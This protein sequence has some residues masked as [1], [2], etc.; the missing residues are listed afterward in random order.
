VLG[1][2]GNQQVGY[3]YDPSWNHAILWTGSAASAVDLHPTNIPL[4]MSEAQATDG[5]HQ[6]GYGLS[7]D[8]NFHALLW[9]GSA[10]T[11]IDLN[12]TQFGG[13][14]NSKAFGI[15]GGQQVGEAYSLGSHTHAAV[16]SGTADS[17][18]DLHPTQF[19]EFNESIAY[20]TNGL[21]QVGVA[22]F[23]TAGDLDRPGVVT[24]SHAMLWDGTA[25]SAV[26]LQLSLPSSFVSS[27]AYSIDAAGDVFGIATDTSGVMH[28][29]EWTPQVPEPSGLA[30]FA[31]GA[32]GVLLRRN[33]VRTERRHKD[34][35]R[36]CAVE[37]LESRRLLSVTATYNGLSAYPGIDQPTIGNS[38]A[39]PDPAIA[40]SPPRPA[41][42]FD[43]PTVGSVVETVNEGIT[44]FDRN[45]IPGSFAMGD[46][47][48][49][50]MPQNTFWASV[51]LTNV[52]DTDL[53]YDTSAN[54]FVAVC[55]SYVDER[56]DGPSKLLIAVSK[57]SSLKPLD[58][59]DSTL[60]DP[61]S[62][63]NIVAIN[64]TS[65]APSLVDQP[66]F[67]ALNGNIYIYGEGNA[68]EFYAVSESKVLNATFGAT[69][70]RGTD[71]KYFEISGTYD[72]GRYDPVAVSGSV[73]LPAGV[74]DYFFAEESGNLFTITVDSHGVPNGSSNVIVMPTSGTNQTYQP[75]TTPTVIDFSTNNA[76]RAWWNNSKLY[77]ADTVE[78][79]D[80]SGGGRYAV[81]WA[82]YSAPLPAST[83]WTVQQQGLE[84]GPAGA[85]AAG[86]P[87]MAVNAEGDMLLAFNACFVY[88][89]DTSY[90][91]VGAYYAIHRAGDAPNTLE[92][93][94]T[95]RDD[96]AGY[97]K[98]EYNRWGDFTSV[99]LDPATSSAFSNKDAS[100]FVMCAEYA[101][102]SDPSQGPP[103][104]AYNWGTEIG[105]FDP[106]LRIK[107]D[108]ANPGDD[109]IVV[110]LA[111]GGASYNITD[112]GVPV[113]L[114][115][116]ATPDQVADLFVDAGTGNNSLTLDVSN[117][118][119]I[120]WAD[121][122]GGDPSLHLIGSN[123]NDTLSFANHDTFIAQL[124]LGDGTSETVRDEYW[125]PPVTYDTAAGNDT[126]SVGTSPTVVNTGSGNSSI[127]LGFNTLTLNT[128]ATGGG[129]ETL[130]ILS[131]TKPALT[132]D[133]ASGLVTL[134]PNLGMGGGAG[135][136]PVNLASL[137]IG[138]GA[139]FVAAANIPD[140]AHLAGHAN[141]SVLVLQPGGL[142]VSGTGTLDLNDNDLI[143][144]GGASESST[145]EALI[146][147]GFNGGAW[148]LDPGSSGITSS[149]AAATANLATGNTALGWASNGDL[150]YGSFDG[151]TV[152]STDLI[153]KY[154]YYGDV[155]LNGAVDAATDLTQIDSNYGMK[156]GATWDLGDFTYEG[157]IDSSD[158]NLAY[159]NFNYGTASK[160]GTQL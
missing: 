10:S 63:W 42:G 109:A 1:L 100:G 92:P 61:S 128:A 65:D 138:S 105:F 139:T 78:V 74:E 59:S 82:Q 159:G 31:L 115:A 84:Y 143:I 85:V 34:V 45:A 158:L 150:A 60:A 46:T 126:I 30:L 80:D 136:R 141:R 156:S 114:P 54:L 144:Q 83:S 104:T 112:N 48:G 52:S 24:I 108:P 89:A 77:V 58:M 120:S 26:D 99:V 23:R 107:E 16:W 13:V 12:P 73:S 93:V 133:A 98:G 39:V 152:D 36:R 72:N 8:D 44:W 53:F 55:T 69:L 116:G 5:I 35:V 49:N 64:T 106:A 2:G 122:T 76:H 146:A 151:V 25:A 117:G 62:N 56:T 118:T 9:S 132:I 91:T 28:A 123:A 37:A 50:T 22:D 57:S 142:S 51:R 38:E 33:G 3:A 20:S 6:V 140:M 4:Q 68:S 17:A 95:L 135:I 134:A 153:V 41:Q 149:E 148:T 7:L 43:P 155:D 14:V 130:T 87:G 127:T 70:I 125:T 86:M 101:A 124:A 94:Q 137:T 154:T 157:A 129:S 71:Y 119:P 47:S 96:G 19:T 97:N 160:P 18:V 90:T 110:A 66:R 75:I 103:W 81:S 121:L 131:E 40:I 145:I 11:T 27:T 88:A 102:K 21:E 111:P 32:A 147:A 29:I 67:D 79:P 15:S 113:T